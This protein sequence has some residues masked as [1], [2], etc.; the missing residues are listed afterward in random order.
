MPK[1]IDLIVSEKTSF[2]K[3]KKSHTYKHDKWLL[4]RI[5]MLILIKERK[6]IYHSTLAAELKKERHTIGIWIKN[7]NEGGFSKLMS[8]NNKDNA[9]RVLPNKVKKFIKRK[10]NEEYGDK[11][12]YS[13]LLKLINSKYQLEIKYAT[14]Y[15]YARTVKDLTNKGYKNIEIGGK[16]LIIPIS[17]YRNKNIK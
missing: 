13:K 2:L 17:S 11:Y 4:K 9:K 7:Y 3:W 10:I 5:E 6:K 8:V 15:K 14:F 16:Q 1:R 12:S